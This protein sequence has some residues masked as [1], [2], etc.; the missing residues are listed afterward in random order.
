MIAQVSA[1]TA[2]GQN[3]DNLPK[4]PAAVNA[5]EGKTFEESTPGIVT[6]PKAPACAPNVVIFLIDDMG[7]G[8]IWGHEIWGQ[9]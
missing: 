1:Q 7:F 9:T 5:K 4:P 3:L 2:Q 8:E 6:I